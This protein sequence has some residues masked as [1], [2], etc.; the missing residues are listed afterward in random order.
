VN[1]NFDMAS[2]AGAGHMDLEKVRA[3]NLGAQFFSIW[4]DPERYRGH[5]AHRTLELI[6]SVYRQAAR[7]PDRMMMAFTADDIVKAP[8]SG[9]EIVKPR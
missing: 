4:P 5:Y 9:P 1:E 6:D 3:G 7:H 8:L 2:S